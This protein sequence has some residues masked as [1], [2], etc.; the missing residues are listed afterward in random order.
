MA[1]FWAFVYTGPLV[2]IFYILMVRELYHLVLEDYRGL[3]TAGR[4]AMYLSLAGAVA[5]SILALL[6]KFTPTMTQS[7]KG[8]F[9]VSAAERGVDTALA[10]FII[11]LLALLS[12]YPIQLRRNVRVQAVIYSIFFLSSTMVLLA[13]MVLGKQSVAT[14]NAASSVISVCSIFAWLVMLS[15][16]G[17]RAPQRRTDARAKNEQRLLL[18]L[19][20]LNAALLRVSRSKIG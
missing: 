17:E 19:E 10:V 11:L 1:Y 18:Q 3:Q 14:L 5:I 8:L 9:L 15:P 13:R 7:S 16:E 2:L 20:E 4:Y 12:R 6:P